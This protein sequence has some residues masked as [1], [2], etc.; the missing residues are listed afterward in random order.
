MCGSWCGPVNVVEILRNAD[1]GKHEPR[2]PGGRT[3]TG[4]LV[5]AISLSIQTSS[6]GPRAQS[7]SPRSCPG[8]CG[9][10]CRPHRRHAIAVGKQSCLPPRR[11]VPGSSHA[12]GGAAKKRPRLWCVH[13]F[14]TSL[15]K[16]ELADLFVN[17]AFTRDTGFRGAI[18]GHTAGSSDLNS[19]KV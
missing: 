10:T 13:A 2:K 5:Q 3:L 9:R 12:A 6:P 15:P 19:K 18:A 17:G 4:T 11:C 14:L 16:H 1:E 7:R 8:R